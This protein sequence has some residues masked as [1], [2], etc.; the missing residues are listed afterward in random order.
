MKEKAP[1]WSKIKRTWIVA[2][3]P[4]EVIF[5]K[6]KLD[7]DAMGECD[8]IEEVIR[9]N[10][11]HKKHRTNSHILET[12]IHE[13]LHAMEHEHEINLGHRVINKLEKPFRDFILGNLL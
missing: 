7:Q 10:V 9:I 6:A 1:H 8:F 11:A 13:L 3:H 12:L 5:T 2:G 4:W